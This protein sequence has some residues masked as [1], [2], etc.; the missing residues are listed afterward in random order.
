MKLFVVFRTAVYR[1]ECGGVFSSLDAA[2][3]CAMKLLQWEPDNH[4]HYEIVSFVLDEP[5]LPEEI[6][7]CSQGLLL[8]P[9]PIWRLTRNP[10]LERLYDDVQ[11]VRTD[12][13]Q[14]E[15]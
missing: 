13:T 10:K 12:R 7:K 6:K 9:E 14:G 3:D 15:G 2:K 4:H 5:T 8:E 11:V 1:H